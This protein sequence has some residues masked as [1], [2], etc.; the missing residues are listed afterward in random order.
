ML[1]P[2]KILK[3]IAEETKMKMSSYKYL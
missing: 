2:L 1:A 3:K